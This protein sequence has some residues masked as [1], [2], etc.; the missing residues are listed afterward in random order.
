MPGLTRHPFQ[1]RH[2]A[3]TKALWAFAHLPC[4]SA[5]WIAARGPQWR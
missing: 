4:R 1:S 3:S 2:G 5:K